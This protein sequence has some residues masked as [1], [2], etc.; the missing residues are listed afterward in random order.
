MTAST[1][2]PTPP[3]RRWVPLTI[4]LVAVGA[5]AVIALGLL[6]NQAFHPSSLASSTSEQS[7]A[8]A[9]EPTPDTTAT[10]SPSDAQPSTPQAPS[11]APEPWQALT[12]PSVPQL[13][14][15]K[16]TVN[17]ND[18]IGSVTTASIQKLANDVSAGDVDKIIRNCWTQPD[19]DLH[20]VY[21][22]APLRG[23][24][25]Q[26]LKQPPVSAQAGTSWK[27]QYVTVSAYSEE[28]LSAY[29]CPTVSW[30]GSVGLGGFTP[31]MA[32]WRITR[33]LAFHDG[34]PVHKGDG[35][36]YMLI[37]NSD[38]NGMWNPRSTG[39]AYS[40]SNVAP[41]LHATAADWDRLR[42]LSQ[43]ALTVEHTGDYYAVRA[44]DGST[45]AVAYFTATYTD[46]WLPYVLGEID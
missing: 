8:T 45:D 6:V 32:Q 46:S 3:R 12:V 28:L 27:G 14:L 21:G 13:A 33:I 9:S 41:I 29:T 43:A 19:S 1:D 25:L 17:S 18:G 23:A 7:A 44:G 37:C 16:I 4:T 26:A 40:D 39:T 34:Q 35:V 10:S 42:Q 30:K 11:S 38:C 24:I 36:D 20:A 2:A 22:S 15:S 31:A 5:A